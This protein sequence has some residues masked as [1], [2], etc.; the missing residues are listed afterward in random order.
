M[1][2]LNVVNL[3]QWNNYDVGVVANIINE[4]YRHGLTTFDEM[5]EMLEYLGTYIINKAEWA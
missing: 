5:S 4:D 3:L 1:L 2:L